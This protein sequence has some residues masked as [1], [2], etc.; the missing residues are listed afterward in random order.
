MHFAI[1]ALTSLNISNNNLC[2]RGEIKAEPSSRDHD[3]KYDHPWGS[4]DKHYESDM[5]SAIAI[6]DGIS[7]NGALVK[8]IF[9]GDSYQVQD[10]NKGHGRRRRNKFKTVTPEPAVL[11][12]GTTEADL[13]NKNLGVGDAMIVGAWISNKDNGALETITFGGKQA[14]T[15]TTTMTEADFSGK[16]LG[17]SGAI[18]VAVFLPKCQ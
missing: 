12:V 13:S 2:R 9:G 6:A 10:V 15:M 16:Q 18:I 4:E 14:V 5:T 3:D 7:A 11:E 1:R 8:L 17:A